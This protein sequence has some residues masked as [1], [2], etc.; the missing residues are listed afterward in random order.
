MVLLA[1]ITDLCDPYY[2][3]PLTLLLDA[4][5]D[6]FIGLAGDRKNIANVWA[7]FKSENC[8]RIEALAFVFRKLLEK[9]G[10]KSKYLVQIRKKMPDW[11]L[12]RYEGVTKK[13]Q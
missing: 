10:I 9:R 13:G 3:I 11:E 6:I 4:N 5:K 2:Y 7:I 12:V 8:Q 1:S